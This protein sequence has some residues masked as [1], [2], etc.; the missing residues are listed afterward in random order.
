MKNNLLRLFALF[1]CALSLNTF[2]A[3]VHNITQDDNIANTFSAASAGDTIRFFPGTYE[4]NL[5]LDSKN[6]TLEG[7]DTKNTILKGADSNNPIITIDGITSATIKNFTFLESNVGISIGNTSNLVISN[8]VF[9]LGTTNTALIINENSSI[10][11]INNTFYGNTTNVENRSLSVIVKNNIFAQYDTLITP[12]IPNDFTFNCVEEDTQTLSFVDIDIDENDFH[13]EADSEC[14]DFI[15][16]DEKYDDAGAYGGE[17]FDKTPDAVTINTINQD[18]LAAIV[19]PWSASKDY[20]V[21]GYKLYYHTE[22]IY[23]E[24]QNTYLTLDDRDDGTLSVVDADDTLSVTL[25]NLTTQALQT[26]APILTRV[27]PG[28]NKLTLSWTAADNANSYVVYYKTENET[29]VELDVGNV[30]SYEITGLNNNQVYTVWLTAKTQAMVYFQLAAYITDPDQTFT[31]SYFTKKDKS[32]TLGDP[33]LSDISNEISTQPEAVV[34][35]PLLPNEGCFIATAAFGHYSA[36]QVQVLRTFRD[37]H[38]LT[39][40]TGRKFVAWY[41][42]YGPHAAKVI[43]QYPWLKPITRAFLFPVIQTAKLF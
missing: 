43:N 32:I 30:T 25:S 33:V 4:V 9:R 8:N 12:V 16:F 29:T 34:P 13:L 31:E 1:C 23:T 22:P 37:K 11:V 24:S 3:A 21:E 41:Y 6:L 42:Q 10:D 20:Q 26:S 39:N 40:D 14:I 7:V 36:D 18:D 38:L 17:Y 2:A 28:K 5:T 27:L 35:Y 19:V 15:E